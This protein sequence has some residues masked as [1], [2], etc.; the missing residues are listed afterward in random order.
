VISLWD[1][2][3]GR[4]VRALRGHREVVFSLAFSPDGRQLA[5]ASDDAM[6]KV[7]DLS[8]GQE[9]QTLRGH[10]KEVNAVAFLPQAGR[11]IASTSEDGTIKLWDS[12]TGADVFTLRGHIKQ[13]HQQPCW[14]SWRTGAGDTA[15]MLLRSW[16]ESL[17][18]IAL[19]E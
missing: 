4:E 18:V 15:L 1:A 14:R 16:L 8:S 5:A 17:C 10:A 3:A 6:I 11:R 7:W 2:E 12:I 13:F 9:D 19:Y